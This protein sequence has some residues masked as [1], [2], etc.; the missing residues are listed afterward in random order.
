MELERLD[1][2]QI[3]AEHDLHK[4]HATETQ[5]VATALKYMN[6][7]CSEVNTTNSE[8]T[9]TVTDEDRKKLEHQRM[10]QQKL[11][12]KHE[13]AINVLRAKQER[14]IKLKL[15]KQQAELQ[16][17]DDQYKKEKKAEEE[18]YLKDYSRLDKIIQTRRGR[19]LQ[20][21]DLKFM[22]WRKDWES[23]HGTIL[24][25]RWPHE[26]WPETFDMDTPI[27]HF[28]S[29]AVYTPAVA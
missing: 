14:F 20:R 7:Y 15:Q 17:L 10:T 5:N 6:A 13:S 11:P 3:N 26:D 28:S 19:V 23:Q 18:Q 12:A 16:H 27:S 1:E 4:A 21:W 22:I 8:F 24:T 2:Y 29:L 25:T 9:H